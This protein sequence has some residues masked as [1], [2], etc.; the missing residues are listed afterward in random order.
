MIK[1]LKSI[2]NSCEAFPQIGQGLYPCPPFDELRVVSLS[3]HR[4]RAG[5]QPPPQQEDKILSDTFW[6]KRLGGIQERR[7]LLMLGEKS[8]DPPQNAGGEFP[9]RTGIP[10]LAG[11]IQRLQ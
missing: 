5:V 11:C 9:K 3:N 10:P 7:Y 8:E 2:R 1:L 6:E 4:K